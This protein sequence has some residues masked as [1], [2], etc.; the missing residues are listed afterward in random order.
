MSPNNAGHSLRVHKHIFCING[1]SSFLDILRHLLEHE[2]YTVT[3]TNFVP[4]TFEQIAALQPSLL[5]ID[6]SVGQ[7]AGPDLLERLQ[8]EAIT[9]KIPVIV[10]STDRRLLARARAEQAHYGGQLF[11][12]KPLDLDNLLEGIHALIGAA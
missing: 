9:R 11:L 1:S 3:T 12:A 6:L 4:Q 2:H 10:V 7:R 8:R 5:I